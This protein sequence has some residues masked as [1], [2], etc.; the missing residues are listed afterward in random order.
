MLQGNG[1]LIPVYA[2]GKWTTHPCVCF[3]EMDHSSRCM[4]QG[5]GPLIPV[6]A[7]GKWGTHLG[8][9]FREMGHPS[10]CMLQG[11]GAPIPV[12]ASGKCTTDPGACFGEM[13]H[14]S[15]NML[16]GMSHPSWCM[17]LGNKLSWCIIQGNESP[18]FLHLLQK[19][20]R[21]LNPDSC[22]YIRDI[23]NDF[24][25]YIQSSC[26]T[27]TSDLFRNI[28]HQ[29]ATGLN[30]NQQSPQSGVRNPLIILKLLLLLH[31]GKPQPKYCDSGRP[32]AGALLYSSETRRIIQGD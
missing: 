13:G 12:Y 6:Y 2:S 20:R 27:L 31:G 3:R 29:V 11:N 14:S 19:I 9:C 15:R 21:N 22:P 16:R 5:N 7:S 30:V 18:V 32:E 10:R 24:R 26:A 8:V 1:P 28:L 25:Y 17:L 4:L 23:L